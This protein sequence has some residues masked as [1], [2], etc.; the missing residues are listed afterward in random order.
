V[1][2]L[3]ATGARAFGSLGIPVTTLGA[4]SPRSSS[5]TSSPRRA[6]CRPWWGRQ[7][8]IFSILVPAYLVVLLAAVAADDGRRA[9]RDGGG[10]ELRVVS[11]VSN[12]VGPE[13]TDTLAALASMAAVPCSCAC[14][15]RASRLPGTWRRHRANRRAGRRPGRAAARGEAFATYAILVLVVLVGQWATS[16]R[17]RAGAAADVT[18]LLRCGQQQHHLPAG[19]GSAGRRLESHAKGSGSPSGSSRGPAPIASRRG[20]RLPIIVRSRR[21]CRVSDRYPLTFRLDFLASAGT[22]VLAPPFVA[23]VPM[24]DLRVCRGRRSPRRFG[25]D[26]AAAVPVVTIGASSPSPL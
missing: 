26:A 7:L 11:R 13:L 17:S 22:L 1:L 19:R 16:G 4:C 3:V 5:V 18:A 20:D 24:Y 9:R 8:P 25:G 15:S 12:F 6:R 23:F 10:R 21:R 2:A 14:G